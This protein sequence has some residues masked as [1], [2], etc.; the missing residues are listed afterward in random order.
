MLGLVFLLGMMVGVLI[1][2]MVID[3]A[4]WVEGIFDGT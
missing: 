3:F 1:G 2:A 4:R